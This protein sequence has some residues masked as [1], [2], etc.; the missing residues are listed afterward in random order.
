M[1]ESAKQTWGQH[2]AVWDLS[3]ERVLMDVFDKTRL[4]PALRTDRGLKA[5]GWDHLAEQFNDRCKSTFHVDQ[6]RSKANRLMMDYE[7][8][9]DVGGERSLSDK[10]W[11]KLI[12][13]MPDNANRLQ[14]FKKSGFAHVD[15]CRH[16]SRG[17]DELTESQ[18]RLERQSPHAPVPAKRTLLPYN[19][20]PEPKRTRV[21]VKPEFSWGP[22]EEKLL[23]FLCWRAKLDRVKSVDEGNKPQVWLETAKELN[24][25][26]KTNFDDDQ[27][28]SKY[29]ELMQLY[30]QFK[31]ATGFLGD[32]ET[33]PK[34]DKEWTQLLQDRPQCSVELQQLQKS[35]GFPHVEVCSLIAGDQ[36]TE[37][38]EPASVNEFLV[39]GVLKRTEVKDDLNTESVNTVA[40]AQASLA[41][42][43]LSQQLP[44]TN[45]TGSENEAT[46]LEA[47]A[48]PAGMTQQLH[49][50]LNM[51]L[52]TSTAYLVMLINDHNQQSDK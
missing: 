35:G 4:D 16:I 38:V 31:R 46:V 44:E 29:V 12:L 2:R 14:M 7:L 49:D 21:N 13:D 51:F 6:L 26:C 18:Q 1:G 22:R 5:R 19:K 15:V 45:T 28:K 36:S 3:R 17:K 50:N 42:D 34:T 41:A 32:L 47:V 52:K 40:S 30:D 39:T 10:D 8:F 20:S 23:L 48:A 33:V 43:I 27:F 11:D 9:K 24:N 37:D 25:I